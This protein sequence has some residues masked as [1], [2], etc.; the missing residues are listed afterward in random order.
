MPVV[1]FDGPAA[2]AKAERRADAA[3]QVAVA[4]VVPGRTAHGVHQLRSARFGTGVRLRSPRRASAGAAPS[5]DQMACRH[6]PHLVPQ[7]HGACIVAKKYL[8]QLRDVIFSNVLFRRAQ[9]TCSAFRTRSFRRQLNRPYF[10]V[11]RFAPGMVDAISQH[12]YPHCTICAR[13][14]EKVIVN[15]QQ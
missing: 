1:L 14:E 15:N 6:Q 5:N 13:P 10:P 4:V 12:Q 8:C 2:L 9:L 3:Q 7:V 11:M